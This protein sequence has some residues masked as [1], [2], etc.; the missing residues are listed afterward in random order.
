M[1]GNSKSGALSPMSGTDVTDAL[2]IQ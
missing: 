1:S 2:D